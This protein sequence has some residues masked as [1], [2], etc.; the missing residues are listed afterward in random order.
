M[1]LLSAK[2]FNFTE[3]H[4]FHACRNQRFFYRFRLKWLDDCLD[5]FHRAK[6][7]TGVPNGK[8]SDSNDSIK[9]LRLARLAQSEMKTWNS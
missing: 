5:L 3:S 6:T 2:S 8:Q 7:R 4:A 9:C 1:T